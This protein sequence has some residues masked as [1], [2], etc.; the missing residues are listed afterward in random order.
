MLLINTN[1]NLYSEAEANRIAAE[2]NASDDWNYIAVHDPK[3]TGYSFINIFD[4]DGE[5][6]SKF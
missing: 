3:G 2:M 4:E 1:G 6:I 5:F